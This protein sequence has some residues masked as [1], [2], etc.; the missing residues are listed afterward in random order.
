M[1]AATEPKARLTYCPYTAL[2]SHAGLCGIGAL[3]CCCSVIKS[4]PNLCNHINCSRPGFPVLYYLPKF[5]NSCSL[6]QW[7]HPTILSSVVPFSSC[8]WYPPVSGS[9]QMSQLFTSGGQSIEASGL[10]SVLPMNIQGWLALGLTDLMSLQSKGL[11][12][13]FSRVTVQILHYSAFFRVQLSHLYMATGKTIA[14]VIWGSPPQICLKLLPSV[15]VIW[16][17]SLKIA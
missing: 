16:L 5:A 4:C 1:W 6:G 9:F 2:K 15:K 7:F 12:R 17:F 13:V 10:S 3:G 14:L 11:S 8:P